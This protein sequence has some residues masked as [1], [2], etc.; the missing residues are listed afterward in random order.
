[1]LSVV[2][3]K[4]ELRR[5]EEEERGDNKGCFYGTGAAYYLVRQESP[6]LAESSL[7]WFWSLFLSFVV[8]TFTWLQFEAMLLVL[9]SHRK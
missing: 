4:S 7:P 5:V 6:G 2:R 1:M 9:A 8:S 3:A